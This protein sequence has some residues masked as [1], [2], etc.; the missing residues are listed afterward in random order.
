MESHQRL[1]SATAVNTLAFAAGLLLLGF[2]P[3][4]RGGNRYVAL[5]LLDLL[6]LLVLVAIGWRFLHGVRGTDPQASLLPNVSR[7]VLFLAL[8]PLWVALLQL[9]PVP[10]VLW[11]ML[12]GHALYQEALLAAQAVSVPFR[13][14]SLT[15]D[16]TWV[17]VLAGIPIA[18]A[19]MLGHTGS[20]HQ[21]NVFIVLWVGLALLQVVVSLLQLAGMPWLFF[22]AETFGNGRPVGTLA[23]PNHL[24]S[25][26][27]MALPLAVMKFRQ[28][29]KSRRN[30]GFA[31]HSGVHLMWGVAVF[32]LL[33]GVLVSWS[34]AGVGTAMLVMT[35]SVV[36]MPQSEADRQ[37]RRLQLWGLVVVL[38]VLLLSAGVGWMSRVWGGAVGADL[39]FRGLLFGSTWRAALE[40]FPFGSGLGSYAVVYPRWQPDEVRGFAEHAH[41]DYVQLLMECGL[42]F[43]VLAG[44]AFC[45]VRE[46]VWN[47]VRHARSAHGIDASRRVKLSCG[48]G[49]LA[50]FLH[51]WVD[52]NLRIPANAMFGAFLLGAFLRPSRLAGAKQGAE[53]EGFLQPTGVNSFQGPC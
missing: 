21:L 25:L 35:L 9:V 22:G 29:D 23:N 3:W 20:R 7:P 39:S 47:L 33:T 27:T 16:A 42:L 1:S 43:V 49:V 41:S 19:F 53:T 10:S 37:Q 40:F 48:L 12:P 26:V 46:R 45:L 28:L 51:S 8:S 18:A 36:L 5:V 4:I 52:F 14:V 15:P 2:A 50:L 38:A 31:G 6:G 17:S 11:A 32:V 24:A 13:P 44:V 30:T 34:R